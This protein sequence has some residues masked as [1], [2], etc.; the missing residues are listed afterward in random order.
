VHGQLIDVG[1]VLQPGFGLHDPLWQLW[2]AP[3]VPPSFEAAQAPFA[4]VQ[5]WQ[6]GQEPAVQHRLSTQFP[7]T[8][9]LGLMHDWPGLFLH[10]P[11]ASQ[12]MVFVQLSVSSMLMTETHDP[13]PPVQAWHLPQVP[14]QQRRSTQLALAQS[15]LIEQT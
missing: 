2:P 9:S 6:T 5:A 4:P 7:V 3:Q 11:P 8:Q 10:V 15:P 1:A 14:L 12:V 13:P